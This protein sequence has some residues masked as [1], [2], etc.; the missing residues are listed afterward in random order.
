MTGETQVWLDVSKGTSSLTLRPQGEWVVRNADAIDKVLH[1]VAA[2]GLNSATFDL[3]HIGRLDTAGASLIHRTTRLLERGGAAVTTAGATPA[4]STLLAA[5]AQGDQAAKSE[6][7]AGNSVV[8]VLVRVGA[9]LED[10]GNTLRELVAF[11]GLVLETLAK[12]IV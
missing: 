3:S 11:L 10:A 5:V 12:T 7:R 8:E 9:A 2:G 6:A 4:Q 1:G